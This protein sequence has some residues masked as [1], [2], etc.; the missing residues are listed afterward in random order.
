MAI[1]S[2]LTAVFFSGATSSLGSSTDSH[3]PSW[4]T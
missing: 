3:V 1:G 4:H 2:G